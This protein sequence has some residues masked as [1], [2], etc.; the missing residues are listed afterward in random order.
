MHIML[1]DTVVSKSEVIRRTYLYCALKYWYDISGVKKGHLVII[2]PLIHIEDN[3][4]ILRTVIT[5]YLFHIWNR[6]IEL[7][8]KFLSDPDNNLKI[9]WL[10]FSCIY[11]YIYT[12]Y[13]QLN[14]LTGYLELEY[15]VVV[16]I[17]SLASSSCPFF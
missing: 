12:I 15:V 16:V 7:A 13:R 2:S 10:N 8:S 5:S 9:S 1:G 11:E 6:T 4:K 14:I 17:I 3:N